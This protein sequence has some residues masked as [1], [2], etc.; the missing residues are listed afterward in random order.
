MERGIQDDTLCDVAII[1]A[2]L[3]ANQNVQQILQLAFRS[4]LRREPAR[5]GFD[6]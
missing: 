1:D 4:V 5:A 2:L 3:K 6:I